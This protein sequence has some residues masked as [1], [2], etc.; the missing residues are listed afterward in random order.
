[1]ALF[2]HRKTFTS[3]IR[4]ANAYNENTQRAN[5]CE[6]HAHAMW[7]STAETDEAFAL[8]AT[9]CVGVCVHMSV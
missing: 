9:G 2:A 7:P 6:N 8:T 5:S 3:F 4:F 1:M